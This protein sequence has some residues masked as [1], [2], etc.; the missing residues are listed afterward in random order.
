MP[1]F[2]DKTGRKYGMQTVIK[3]AEN[4]RISQRTSVVQWLCRCDCGNEIIVRANNLTSGNTKSCGCESAAMLR[5]ARFVNYSG[6]RFG[7]LTVICPAED[8]TKL[9][10]R[11]Q[12]TWLCQCDCGKQVIVAQDG[13][14]YGK[15]KSCGCYRREISSQR[16][17]DDLT[18][19]RYGFLTVIRRDGIAD[20]DKPTWLCKCDCGKE[21]VVR[22]SC[23]K[24]G[25][26][27]SC[28]CKKFSIGESSVRS[29]LDELELQYSNQ[30]TFDDLNG[31]GN[32]K[33][34]FDFA[35][36]NNKNELAGLIEYQGQQHYQERINEN[37][38]KVQREITDH[39]KKEYCQAHDIPLLEIKYDVK[40]KRSLIVS[41]VNQLNLT[42]AN[43]V[44]SPN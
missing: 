15:T 42:Y 10:R 43:T 44:P 29:I 39:Q 18:G 37:F 24:N 20:I 31:P 4:H 3:R 12:R 19:R 27:Q 40:D 2:D 17:L 36:Y 33:L 16:Y 38:G 25:S 13:L 14:L 5:A 32:R 1:K 28:G 21:V 34:K 35:L 26:T 9:S 7:R 23:L 22:G 8:Q 41:F 30:K 6:Q 11:K